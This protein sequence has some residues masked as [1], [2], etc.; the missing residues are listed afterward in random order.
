[1][2]DADIV[3]RS[4]AKEW[5]TRKEAAAFLGAIGCPIAP[6]TLARMA[7]NNNQGR[8]PPYTVVSHRI[9]RYATADLRKWA[10]ARTRRVE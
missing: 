5:L 9:V 1:M 3:P 8:G 6:G 10:Q 4:G 7:N 2:T